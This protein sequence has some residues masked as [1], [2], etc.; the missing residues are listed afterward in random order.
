M[1]QYEIESERL[2]LR[3]PSV[4]DVGRL[5]ELMSED[6]TE[7][8]SWE[9][10]RDPS[11][12]LAVVESLIEA[13]KNERGYHWC[14]C[15]NDYII[16]LVSLIDVKR[17]I[18]TWT[19]DRSEL[20]YWI[21]KDYQGK[22]YVTEACRKIIDF[23]FNN[24]NLHKIIVAHAAQ[25]DRSESVCK[26]LNFVKYSHEHDAFKKQNQWHDLIWYELIKDYK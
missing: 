3:P 2:I 13:Q 10:H 26:K 9:P 1:P 23:G 21:G 18:R 6:I 11:T 20:S 19:L 24:L 15:L 7:F 14:I 25:N 8:L 4:T 12:T 22:G 17:K 5:F 16:G